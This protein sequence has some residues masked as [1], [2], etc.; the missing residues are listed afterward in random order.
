MV[1][2]P[3]HSAV[4]PSYHRAPSV[5]G[6]LV[7]MS[8]ATFSSSTA[9]KFQFV[10]NNALQD[11][12]KQTGVDLT[13]YDFTS[14][15]Q[16]CG[17]LDEVCM[18]LRD[19]IRMFKE[20][21]DGNRKL[22]AWIIPVMQFVHVFAGFLGETTSIVSR[23]VFKPFERLFKI[24]IPQHPA[25]SPGKAIFAGVDVLLAVCVSFS[26]LPGPSD[27]YIRWP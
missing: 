19:K 20:Y 21:R 16:R 5:S 7:S 8:S 9:F 11:Y 3:T 15:F 6:L 27:V 17:S 24:L 18:L 26:L 25:L 14:Q 23:K 12:T 22:A 10:P 4:H 2:R 1:G 13:K